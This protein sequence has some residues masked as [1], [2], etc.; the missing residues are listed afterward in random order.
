MALR[1]LPA[2][3][4]TW[5]ADLSLTT[6]WKVGGGRVWWPTLGLWDACVWQVHS[7]CA[8]F[9]RGHDPAR[10]LSFSLTPILIDTSHPK[11]W[12]PELGSQSANATAAVL[13]ALHHNSTGKAHGPVDRWA[14]RG[15]RAVR[16]VHPPTIP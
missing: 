4:L 3:N 2:A 5:Q 15:G 7:D 6:T 13:D 16:A 14:G 9:Q 11:V 1:L 10:Q 12:P 8:L